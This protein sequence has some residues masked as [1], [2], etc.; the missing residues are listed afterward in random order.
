MRLFS[1]M[2][3]IILI[4]SSLI[5]VSC[6]SEKQAVAPPQKITV[7]EVI[8][9]DVPIYREFVGE[10][11]GEK[12]IPIRARVEGYLEGIHFDEGTEVKQGQLLYS[13]DPLPFEAKVNAQQ[14]ELAATKTMMVKAESDL[15]RI[16]PLAEMNAVSKSDLDASQAQYDAYIFSVEA[17]N[18]NLRS[19]QIELGYCKI[20][21]PIN[22]IIGMTKARV[23]DFVG[24]DPNPVILNTVSETNHIK[25]RFFL[26]ESDYLYMSREYLARL[27]AMIE[28]PTTQLKE[29]TP[30]VQIILSDGSVYEH[31]GLV[32][33]IDRGIDPT[34]GSILVQ[35]DF[36][37][38]KLI[39]RPGLYAKVKIAI[40]LVEDAILIPQRCIMELQGLNSVYVVNDSNMV[41]SRQ[42]TSGPSLGDY[43]L[44]NEGLEVGD[45]VVIDALQKVGEG[46]IIEPEIIKFES[47][48]KQQSK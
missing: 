20:Y 2:L 21:S 11:Y 25:V 1:S 22:G 26:T 31:K 30:N 43:R 17:A 34:T 9:D 28:E 6:G 29:Q 46:M 36:P 37:N 44:I 38:P 5:W 33:F 48:T 41:Q 39:L 19:A 42:I 47:K 24:R 23:G 45:K 4:F 13:I 8:T 10:I 18:A 14:S 3:F 35:A 15:N 32:D 16:K 7:V 40:R 27:E 12:D